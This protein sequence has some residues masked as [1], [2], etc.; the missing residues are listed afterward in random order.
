MSYQCVVPSPPTGTQSP[1]GLSTAPAEAVS[2][3][4]AGCHRP[5]AN[6]TPSKKGLPYIYRW[7]R[8]GRQGQPCR[9][10]VRGNKNRCLVEFADGFR[11]MTSRN[12]LRKLKPANS[13]R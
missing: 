6:L 13:V 4:E 7:R 5:L 1:N 11:M 8:E 2:L 3:K 9:V 10:L 12:A